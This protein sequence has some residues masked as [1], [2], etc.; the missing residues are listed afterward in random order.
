MKGYFQNKE[1]TDKVFDEEGW[2][3]T[4]DI[5]R[6]EKGYLKIT[7]RLK[8]MLKTSL[9]K[10]IYPTQIENV[11][12]KSDRIDQIFIIGDKRE[13]L[14]A[15][16]VPSRET[17]EVKLAHKLPVMDDPSTLFINDEE[18]RQ[19]IADDAKKLGMG[20]AKFERIRNFLVKREPFSIESGEMT[21]TL[22]V[23]RKVV[24]ERYA[25]EIDLMYAE[26][27]CPL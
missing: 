22:K 15:I 16:I 17:V 18:L 21:I 14:T 8:N 25:D 24:M 27:E 2:F 3:H 10:N 6:F 11:Y 5:G 19:W 9:G 23:K 20:M 26:K 4:G 7:D 13:Y 1:E 12:L